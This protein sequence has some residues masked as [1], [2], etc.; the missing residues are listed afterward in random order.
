MFR[1]VEAIK[2]IV[3]QGATWAQYMRSSK[4]SFSVGSW[5][6]P[7]RGNLGRIVAIP[8]LT[9]LFQPKV[10]VNLLRGTAMCASFYDEI[11]FLPADMTIFKTRDAALIWLPA[12]SVDA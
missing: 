5:D 8:S 6:G 2:E 9:S 12:D 1:A 7:A 11:K 4:T 10:I 3:T